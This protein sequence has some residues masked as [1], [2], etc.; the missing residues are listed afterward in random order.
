[1]TGNLI[2]F[3]WNPEKTVYYTTSDEGR[4]E[5]KNQETRIKKQE[6]RRRPLT[7]QKEAKMTKFK[8]KISKLVHR[9]WMEEIAMSNV[10]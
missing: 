7:A 2:P 3:S 10:K 6:S 9:F 5:K 4:Q 8:I 1:V